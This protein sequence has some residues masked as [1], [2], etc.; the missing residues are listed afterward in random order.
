MEILAWVDLVQTD[1]AMLAQVEQ[2]ADMQ[3][4]MTI[5]MGLVALMIVIATLVAILILLRVRGMMKDAQTTFH[6]L[7]PQMKPALQKAQTAVGQVTEVVDE[8]RARV[9][10]VA[11]TVGDANDALREA[12]RAAEVRIR[13]LAAVVDVVREETQ[14]L[15]LDGAA[16]AHGIHTTAKALRAPRPTGKAL[17]A[18][19]PPPIPEEAGRISNGQG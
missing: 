12:V 2:I 13:E 3:R 15:L 11:T 5:A 7:A 8:V 1:A 10:D 19:P 4:W 17:R 14:E 6:R 16:T 18:E 9:H